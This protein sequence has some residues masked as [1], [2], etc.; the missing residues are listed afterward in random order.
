MAAGG[1][2]I[3]AIIMECHTNE[4][5]LLTFLQIDAVTFQGR[6]FFIFQLLQTLIKVP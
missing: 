6:I 1:E 2:H 4:Y 3:D 5:F